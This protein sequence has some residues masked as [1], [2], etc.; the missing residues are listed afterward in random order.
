MFLTLLVEHAEKNLGRLPK[1][2]TYSKWIFILKAMCDHIY[3]VSQLKS[4]YQRMRVDYLNMN[5]LK[6]HTRLGWDEEK[7][8]VTCTKDK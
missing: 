4:K 1:N 6:N 7:Q 5:L 8:R 3:E 2:P